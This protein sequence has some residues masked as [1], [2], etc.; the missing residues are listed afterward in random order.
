MKNEVKEIELAEKLAALPKVSLGF[1]PTPLHKLEN[2]SKDLGV[3][4]YIKRDDF[5]GRN[6]FGGNKIRKLEYLLGDAKKQGCEYVFTYGATQSN[7]AMQ[8][9]AACRTV[10]LKPVLYL[11][12]IVPVDENDIRSNLLLDQI[13]D[14]EI[15]IVSVQEGE[16][17]E[18]AEERSFVMAA[19][20][21][22]ELEAEG[23]KCYNVPMGGASYVGSTAFMGGYLELTKQM[24]SFNLHADY[25]FHATGTGG[26]LAGLV[27][28]KKAMESDTEI[29]SV[30]V[31]AKD[32]SYLIHVADL[33]NEALDHLGLD[34]RIDGFKDLHTDLNYYAPGYEI[35]N[36]RAKIAIKYLASMEGLLVDPVYTGKAF[37]GLLDY[38][39]TGKVKQGSTVVFWHTGGATALFAEKS[40]VGL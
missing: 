20:R 14:A 8:T 36:E 22:K 26:T 38:I 24:E 28:G 5:S 30:N 1:F 19:E 32:D 3:N 13:F 40:I 31:S 25:L 2:I 35:P 15:H 4:L 16:T 34:T 18:Q 39:R 7:H 21:Q 33:A 27:A 10:G 29:V 23:H 11:V 37:A 6:L 9:A 17:E 12:A